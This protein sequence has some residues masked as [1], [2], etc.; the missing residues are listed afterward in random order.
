MTDIVIAQDDPILDME[1]TY[2]NS[3]RMYVCKNSFFEKTIDTGQDYGIS[4]RD[5]LKFANKLE[6][7]TH[8]N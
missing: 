3:E 2:N 6:E 7:S 1:V 4:I 8:D 5:I